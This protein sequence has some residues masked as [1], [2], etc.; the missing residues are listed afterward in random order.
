MV[1]SP[2][3]LKFL[4]GIRKTRTSSANMRQ[5]IIVNQIVSTNVQFSNFCLHFG[6]VTFFLYQNRCHRFMNDDGEEKEYLRVLT[7]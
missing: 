4:A 6:G 2:L 1:S 7:L 3:D 5:S